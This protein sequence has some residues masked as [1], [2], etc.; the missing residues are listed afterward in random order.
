MRK[1]L[2]L[3]A[4][5]LLFSFGCAT[6][7]K[8]QKPIGIVSMPTWF[9]APPPELRECVP[10]S[11]KMK[12]PAHLDSFGI[13]YE[14]PGWMIYGVVRSLGTKELI[15]NG[16]CRAYTETVNGLSSEVIVDNIYYDV[17]VNG[18]DATLQQIAKDCAIA[19]NE[20]KRREVLASHVKR[21]FG[22]YVLF[23]MDPSADTDNNLL[24]GSG[25]DDTPMEQF[26]TE[27]PPADNHVG[28]S[29]TDTHYENTVM[30]EIS[31]NDLFDSFR[32]TEEN[33]IY[34]FAKNIMVKFSQ[35][36]KNVVIGSGNSTETTEEVRKEEI[37]LRVCGLHV[38][39]R[40]V[41]LTSNTCIVTVTAPKNGI[42][43]L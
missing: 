6:N 16:T 28:W 23:G 7:R 21:R 36:S 35:M 2:P 32:R 18:T 15:I 14:L 41:D 8:D 25:A 31:N 13:K 5:L 27:T 26:S 19:E 10:V 1:I 37:G 42:T 3:F 4:L 20:L 43:L 30:G 17:S 33:A 38:I 40:K 34:D 12:T 24:I 39:R 22:A 11:L 9:T 29:E